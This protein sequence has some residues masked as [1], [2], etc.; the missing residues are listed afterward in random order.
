MTRANMVRASLM[1]LAPASMALALAVGSVPIDVFTFGRVL[2]GQETGLPATMVLELRAPRVVAAFTVG[3]LL[4]L[5]GC[6]LQVL[7]RNPLADPYILGVSGGASVAALAVLLAGLSGAWVSGGALAGGLVALLAVFGLSHGRGVW[8]DTR[9]LLTGVMVAAGGGAIVSLMLSLAPQNTLSSLLF[10]L[11]GDLDQGPNP[12]WGL[13]V[14]A[15]SM[16]IVLP[17]GRALNLFARGE[18]VAA[19]LGENAARIRYGLFFVASLLAATAVTLAGTIGFVGLVVPHLIRRVSGADHRRL[20]ID[21]PIAGGVLL[22]LADTVARTVVAP[23]QL[24]VGAITAI[25]GVPMFLFLLA[26]DA[27]YRTRP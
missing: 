16:L 25:L 22:V 26:R 17:Y 23:A 13:A 1:L 18:N 27:T 20:L 19:A 24:P 11:L 7:L 6:L 12:L 5:S 14:L 9:V 15:L 8:N 21:A 3:G 10:W 2:T 4:A